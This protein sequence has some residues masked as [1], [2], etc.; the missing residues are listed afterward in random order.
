[1]GGGSSDTLSKTAEKPTTKAVNEILLIDSDDS[2]TGIK[3]V[4]LHEFIQ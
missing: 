4:G 2:M 3:L 1:M